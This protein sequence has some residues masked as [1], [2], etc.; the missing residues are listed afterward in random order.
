M[1]NPQ[2]YQRL[3]NEID[4]TVES[5]KLTF[6]AKHSEATQLPYL[7]ACIKEAFRIFPSVQLNLARVVP[8]GGV[9]LNGTYIPHGYRVGINPPVVH[10]DKDV[11]GPD[12]DQFRPDRWLQADAINMDTRLI[13][14]GAGT[15]TCIGENISIV[16]LHKFT[17]YLL[18]SF[19]QN[20][21]IQR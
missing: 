2:I 20:S 1:K 8:E 17:P 9:Q 21:D 13:H 12:A 18:C 15:R 11:F 7:C 3:L 10:F 6:P 4:E 14:F 5:G 16:E 19:R